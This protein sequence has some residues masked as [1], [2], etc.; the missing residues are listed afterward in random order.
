MPKGKHFDAAEKYFKTKEEKYRQQIKNLERIITQQQSDIQNLT[1]KSEALLAE[2]SS[3]KEWVER[4]LSYT[5][6]S[7]EDIKT[8]CERDTKH[9]EAIISL[10]HLFNLG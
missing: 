8:V 5:E 10:A 3:L 9:C 7:K 1:D 4:L 2:N 6:L